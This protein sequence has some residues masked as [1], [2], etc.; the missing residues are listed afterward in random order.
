MTKPCTKA[1]IVDDETQI[2]KFLNVALEA[3]KYE[4]VEAGNG[5]EALRLSVARKPDI[6]ILDLGLPDKDGME[7]IRA[8]R[9]FS[10]VPIIVLSVRQDEKDKVEALDLG[11]NDYVTKP[12]NVAELLARMRVCLRERLNGDGLDPIVKIGD[13]EADL[14]KHIVKV[15]GKRIKL[16]RKEYLL[17]SYLLKNASKLMT[18]KEILRE[19]W[20]EAHVFD[21]QYL[22]VYIGQLRQKIERDPSHPQIIVT[23]PGIGY[24][25]VLPEKIDAA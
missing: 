9:G 12:F 6:I 25:L 8:I 10:K 20:G 15:R 17:F 21:S 24:R 11:A 2:R 14:M 3:E 13:I 23:E 18:Q 7:I 22:R 1:L 19:V 5:E 4:V 16:S